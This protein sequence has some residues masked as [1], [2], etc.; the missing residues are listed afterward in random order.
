V[1]HDGKRS[2]FEKKDEKTFVSWMGSADR[3]SGTGSDASAAKD[4]KSF[5]S[6]FQKRTA[7]LPLAYLAPI[8]P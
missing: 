1:N 8:A 4:Q 5:G 3:V 2:F 6:F 7:S